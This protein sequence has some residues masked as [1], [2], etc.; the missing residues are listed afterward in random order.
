[1]SLFSKISS[2][3]SAISVEAK[4]LPNRFIEGGW[5]RMGA[6]SREPRANTTQELVSSI[7]AYAK[8]N[9]EIAEFAKQINEMKPEHLG[10]AQ[11]VID[12]AHT[13]E[14]I[15]T[16]INLK[17]ASRVPGK[18]NFG[19]ILNSIP[20]ISRENPAALDLTQTVINNS[21]VTNAK[22][23]LT[24]FFGYDLANAKV[25]SEQMKA[26][27]DVVPAIAKDTLEGGYTMDYSKNNE[28]FDFILTLC[29]SD[30]KPENIKMLKPIIDMLDKI[31]KKTSPSCNLNEIRLGDTKVIKDNLDAL[32]YLLENAE[33]QGKSVDISAF[34]TKNVNLK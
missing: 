29:S 22:F 18:T 24:K 9:P 19:V 4:K 1:M 16:N 6:V 33:A 30:S 13:H 17:Q 20:T 8:E 7:R 11:D 14:M 2:G 27:E 3:A 23:F 25:A 5:M 28:F 10:L 26:A 12:L 15:N 31:C 32:P 34:L 21:D